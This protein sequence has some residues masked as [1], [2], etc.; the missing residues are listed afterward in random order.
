MNCAEQLPILTKFAVKEKT[1]PNGQ[2][3]HPPRAGKNERH[4][5]SRGGEAA[6]FGTSGLTVGNAEFILGWGVA[7]PL[8]TPRGQATGQSSIHR[9][10]FLTSCW[11]SKTNS[12]E[13]KTVVTSD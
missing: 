6:P 11:F 9:W 4:P 10:E 13:N 2:H 1:P 8:S 12:F 7:M 3:S 5:F